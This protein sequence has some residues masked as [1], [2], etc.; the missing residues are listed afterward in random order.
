MQI[1]VFHITPA[2]GPLGPAPSTLVDTVLKWRLS[3]PDI[4]VCLWV[5]AI[6]GILIDFDFGRVAAVRMSLLPPVIGVPGAV[7]ARKLTADIQ[8]CGRANR[9]QAFTPPKGFVGCIGPEKLSNLGE[10]AND[11]LFKEP[12]PLL[13]QLAQMGGGL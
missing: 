7:V 5:P 6:P 12:P 10:L 11:S 13:R 3:A 8:L 9:D 1:D 4:A 2:A